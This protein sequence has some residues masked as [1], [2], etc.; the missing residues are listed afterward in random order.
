MLNA[1]ET[2][3]FLL[4]RIIQLDNLKRALNKFNICNH[5]KYKLDKNQKDD[6]YASY[7]VSYI[8]SIATH[9]CEFPTTMMFVLWKIRDVKN[10]NADNVFV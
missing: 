2:T 1:F 10:I 8:H 9:Q 4:I 6:T 5:G 7:S 3:V